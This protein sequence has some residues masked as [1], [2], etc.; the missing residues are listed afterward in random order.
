MY[1]GYWLGKR[2]RKRPPGRLRYSWVDNIKM[3]LRE[4]DIGWDVIDWIDVPQNRD[5]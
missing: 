4:R 3:G 1:I 5:Q 2:K